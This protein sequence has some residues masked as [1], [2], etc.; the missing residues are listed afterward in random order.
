ML[1]FSFHSP[2]S[3]SLSLLFLWPAPLPTPV[4]PP[5]AFVAQCHDSF[6]FFSF[7][8]RLNVKSWLVFCSL[9]F[10]THPQPLFPWP[11]TD[12]KS[13]SQ[14]PSGSGVT[15]GP[16]G[17]SAGLGKTSRSA[18]QGTEVTGSGAAFGT[19]ADRCVCTERVAPASGGWA[20]AHGRPV[21][22]R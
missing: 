1:F 22:L 13:W 19:W 8:L 15:E 4:G 16:R 18:G 9:G 5:R 21:L 14:A 2:L 6:F 10:P 20:E 12:P 7:F 3:L 11:N 17:P